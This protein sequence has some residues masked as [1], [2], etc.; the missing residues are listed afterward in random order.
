[1]NVEICYQYKVSGTLYVVKRASYSALLKKKVLELGSKGLSYPEIQ[2]RYKVPKSTLSSWFSRHAGKPKR[3]RAQMLKHLE[4]ARVLSSQKK[5]SQK[6]AWMNAAKTEGLKK[7]ALFPS[8]NLTLLKSLLSML[9]WC[10][11]SKH[12]DVHGLVFVNTDPDLMRLYVSLLRAC[13][14]IDETKLK[15]RV[16]IHSYHDPKEVLSFWSRELRIPV[17]Q[18]GKIYVKKRSKQKKFRENFKGICF[19]RYPDNF[20]REEL[21]SLGRGLSKKFS[22]PS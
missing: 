20:A 3:T 9:Y 16:H 11:G 13:L 8:S 18:F 1:M 19:V 5:R 7:A 10:E 21:L 22:M 14:D 6:E 12:K 4:Y 2:K 15:A 17:S